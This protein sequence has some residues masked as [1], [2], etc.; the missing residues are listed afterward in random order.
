VIAQIDLRDSRSV[1]GAPLE[2]QGLAMLRFRNG[3]FGLMC[4][5][6]KAPHDVE[7]RLL[8]TTGLIELGRPG[9]T[10]LRIMGEGR[11]GW[12][13]LD[14]KP[15]LHGADCHAAAVADLVD[16]LKTGREPE[17]SARRALQATEVIFAAYESSRRGGRV[18]LPLAV[19]DS[20][21][22]AMLA[23]GGRTGQ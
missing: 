15:Q 13:V 3:V 4:T 6:A 10:G 19:E 1:F 20:P 21:L 18:D 23:A 7:F 14:K 2:G 12:E 8:G 17:L 16:A 11:R 5:G 9:E 22:A